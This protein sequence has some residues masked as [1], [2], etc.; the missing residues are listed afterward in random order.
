MW[1]SLMCRL[2]LRHEWH[3]ENTED[4]GHYKRCRRCGKYHQGPDS[5]SATGAPLGL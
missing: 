1:R 4:G 2:N 3:T 5:T